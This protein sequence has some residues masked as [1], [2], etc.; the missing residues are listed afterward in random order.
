MRKRLVAVALEALAIPALGV[1]AY[2]IT[3]SVSD[4]PEPQV[5]LP[6][7]SSTTTAG[8][9]RAANDGE[10]H[11]SS[12]PAPMPGHNAGEHGVE[13][14]AAGTLPG[15]DA[16]DDHG[17]DMSSTATASTNVAIPDDHRGPAT[18]AP[19]EMTAPVMLTPAAPTTSVA[20]NRGGGSGD[21]GT[22]DGSAHH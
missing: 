11:T 2:G 20:D 1:A 16:G 18:I 21:G 9:H 17:A 15:H 3:H 12:T 13:T 22:V 10:I 5:V 19:A 6:A 14:P 4:S 8:P 7:S